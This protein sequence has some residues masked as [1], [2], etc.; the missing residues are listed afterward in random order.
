MIFN[1]FSF[2]IFL[3][4]SNLVTNLS[5]CH[6]IAKAGN[7]KVGGKLK[8]NIYLSK[9]GKVKN[10]KIKND[11][12]NSPL[13]VRCVRYYLLKEKFKPGKKVITRVYNFPKEKYQYSV[14]SK[15]IPVKKKI[16]KGKAIR[17]IIN[18]KSTG[19]KRGSL[20]ILRISKG[21]KFSAHHHPVSNTF[22]FVLGGS[23]RIEYQTG[24]NKTKFVPI[25]RGSSLFLPKKTAHEIK[26]FSDP[27]LVMAVFY[28]PSNAEKYLRNGV[29]GK[30]INFLSPLNSGIKNSYSYKA[31][32]K[33]KKRDY[34]LLKKCGVKIKNKIIFKVPKVG[35]LGMITAPPKS[36][37]KIKPS[38]RGEFIGFVIRGGGEINIGKQVNV[39]QPGSGIYLPKTGYFKTMIPKVPLNIIYLSV[40]GKIRVYNK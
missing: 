1:L 5:S 23:G 17:S 30:G 29:K 27:P 26:G 36:R 15:D 18:K 20:T 19:V 35:V 6:R 28:T 24:K 34:I 8:V 10:I 39:V 31:G 38:K 11:T 9:S 7:Y 33:V 37:I 21:E 40:T 12:I 3:F 16:G 14:W 32:K 2:F 25:S 13:M 4:P 22:I